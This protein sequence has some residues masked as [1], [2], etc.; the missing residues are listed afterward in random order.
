LP[1]GNYLLAVR[2]QADTTCLTEF[3]GNPVGITAPVECCLLPTYTNTCL[4]GDFADDFA[5]GAFTNLNTGCANPGA[6]NLSCYLGT[7]ANVQLNETY[8]VIIEAGSKA[9]F[10]GVYID[11]NQNENYLDT[12]EFFDIGQAASNGT[13]TANVTI[14]S[15]ALLGTTTLRVRSS[16]TAPL[17]GSDGCA[18]NLGFGEIEDYNLYIFCPNN[19]AVNGLPIPDGTY[20]ADVEITSFGKVESNANVIFQAGT[21]V[22]LLGGFEVQAGGLFQV[23]VQGCFP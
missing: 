17:T 21:S 14:P 7:G 12:G 3:S 6:N 23:V 9:Q 22:M 11:F 1:L 19:L 13:V 20:N 15:S 5:F 8:Q 4:S 10:F 18:T 2:L 16:F